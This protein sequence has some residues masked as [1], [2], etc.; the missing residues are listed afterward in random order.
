MAW[1]EERGTA[2]VRLVTADDCDWQVYE[3]WGLER[4]GEGTASADPSFGMY[5]YQG[6][7][8]LDG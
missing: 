3:H 2:N 5:V 7:P 8:R 1:F 4:V 6:W